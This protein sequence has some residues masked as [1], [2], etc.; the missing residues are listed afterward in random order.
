MIKG[1]ITYFIDGEER[2]LLGNDS[3]TKEEFEELKKSNYQK[4]FEAGYR[5][6]KAHYY[7]KWYRYNRWDEGKAY[8]DGC[9]KAVNEPHSKKWVEEDE[10]F[11]IIE[12]IESKIN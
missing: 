5:D 10:H 8:D 12:V 7:D 9:Q 3:Y 2:F 6:R 4:D 11:H 1:L